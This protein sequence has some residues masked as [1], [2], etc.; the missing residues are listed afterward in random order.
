MASAADAVISINENKVGECGDGKYF[1]ADIPAGK[2]KIK[3][4]MKASPGT[5]IAETTLE[6]GNSY[7]YEVQVNEAYIHSGVILG[8]IGQSAYVASNKNSA[9]WVLVQKPQEGAEAKIKDKIYSIDG[10]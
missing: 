4:T 3:A 1:F 5:H 10:E 9:A 6:A 7:Y 8:V 2:V